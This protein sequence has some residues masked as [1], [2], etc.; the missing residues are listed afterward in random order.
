M[1]HSLLTTRRVVPL[2]RLEEYID[3]WGRVRD[4]VVGQGGRAWLF[5]AAARE[6]SFLEFIEF[7]ERHAV[8]RTDELQVARE[9]LAEEFGERET[10]EWE[11]FE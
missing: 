1:A 5:R 8:L 6:D 9:S 10:E 11:E 4:L 7:E 3:S 2:D